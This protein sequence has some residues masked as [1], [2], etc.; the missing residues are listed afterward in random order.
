MQ[1]DRANVPELG[2]GGCTSLITSDKKREGGKN[3]RPQ[4]KNRE[5]CFQEVNN[6]LAPHS[7]HVD[8]ILVASSEIFHEFIADLD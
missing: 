7:F 1:G 5:T 2:A 4:Q 6:Q 3:P 8:G